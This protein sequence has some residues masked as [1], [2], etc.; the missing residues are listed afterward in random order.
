MVIRKF[1]ASTYRAWR[2]GALTFALAAVCLLSFCAAVSAQPV[3]PPQRDPLINMLMAQPKIDLSAPIKPAAAF[4]PPVIGVGEESFY[5]VSFNALEESIKMPAEL[6]VSGRAEVKPRAQG[7]I[8]QMLPPV[9]VPLSVFNYRVR[10]TAPGKIA[11]PSFTAQVYGSN[12][13]IPATELEVISIPTPIAALPPKLTVEIP[14]TKLFVGQAAAITVF[15][16]GMPGG[17]GGG[18]SPVQMIGNG[19]VVDQGVARQMIQAIPRNGVN[20]MTYT[21]ETLL[22]PLEAG[23]LTFFA[24]GFVNPNRFNGPVII[25]SSG[26]A[27][28]IPQF[29]LFESDDIQL[30]VRP[31]PREGELPGFTGAIGRFRLEPPSLTTN[32]LR[33]GDPVRLTVM[34]RSNAIPSNFARLVPPPAPSARD[35]QVLAAGSDS[36]P[37]A[38]VQARGFAEF[39]YTLIPLTEQCKSTPPI[40]FSYF[41]PMEERYVDLTI[42]PVEVRVS[43][44]QIPADLAALLETGPGRQDTERLPV[45]SGTAAKP[46]R[47]VASLV[48]LQQQSWFMGLQ[49][50][51]AVGLGGLWFWDRRRRYLEQHPEVVLRRRA[52]RELRRH[53]HAL[54][55]AARSQDAKAFATSAVDAMRAVAAPHYPAEPRALVGRDILQLLAP[56]DALEGR[57][58]SIVQR[59]F[60]VTDEASFSTASADINPLLGLQ[61][62][63]TEVLARLEAKL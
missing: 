45:L 6:K 50:A 27:S 51:P 57:L 36:A 15:L 25:N 58:R 53:R 10:A 60:A 38:F 3:V 43:P 52:R 41:D 55:K 42:P 61:P 16:P 59:F 35:W 4:D 28:I 1:V 31:L 62:E 47:S 34:V 21:Y 8:F 11:I 17:S 30:K 19:L 13:T 32:S 26:I 12:V 5:R 18:S 48:P 29:T 49:L 46:G 37:A 39:Y 24:Q 63:L 14:A 44:G 40:P 54:R 2:L 23:T 22:T 9:M 56:G 20:V 7:Q 33:V